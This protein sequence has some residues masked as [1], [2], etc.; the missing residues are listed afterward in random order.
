MPVLLMMLFILLV[1]STG[2]Y[3]AGVLALGVYNGAIIGEALRAGIQSLPKG[4]REAGLSIGL[5]P[6]ATRFLIEFPQAFRQMLPIII[7]QLVVLLKDTSLAY[8]VG[9][10]ELL[11]SGENLANFFGN[12]Y[13]FSFFFIVLGMYLTMNLTLSWVA[14]FVARRTAS[15]TGLAAPKDPGSE[16]TR[17]MDAGMGGTGG[18]QP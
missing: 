12:R 11:R 1:F 14:R 6:V 16:I 3:G 10:T 9:Y 2:T 13:L 18:A 4:Q 17:I 7:A 5:T 8:I 15:K